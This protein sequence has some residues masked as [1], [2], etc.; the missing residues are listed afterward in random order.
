MWKDASRPAKKEADPVWP[1]KN[2]NA[3]TARTS[4]DGGGEECLLTDAVEIGCRRAEE[5]TGEN[6]KL[7]KL[8]IN[9]YR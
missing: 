9:L 8:S 7:I 2:R 6:N 1:K 3:C 4:G 5:K